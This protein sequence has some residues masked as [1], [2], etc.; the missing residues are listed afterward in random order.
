MLYDS[1]RIANPRDR[2]FYAFT[3]LLLCWRKRLACVR[4]S[5]GNGHERDARTSVRN[6]FCSFV[7]FVFDEPTLSRLLFTNRH[8]G[9]EEIFDDQVEANAGL[10]Q[11]QSASSVRKGLEKTLKVYF[12]F[13]TSMKDVPDYKDTYAEISELAKAAKNS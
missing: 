11:M 7:V 2:V 12:N 5:F 8:L 9:F 6:C 10:R 4:F 1:S 13:L 3:V